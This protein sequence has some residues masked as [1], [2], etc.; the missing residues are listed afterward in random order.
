[1]KYDLFVGGIRWGR[2]GAEHLG[3]F[4][5]FEG[6]RID[7]QQLIEQLVVVALRRIYFS[8]GTRS[9]APPG[10][11]GSSA[12]APWMGFARRRTNISQP[13]L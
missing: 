6:T 13:T 1:V 5:L 7:S 12:G 10:A 3:A 9:A 4:V 8:H 11:G 2:I